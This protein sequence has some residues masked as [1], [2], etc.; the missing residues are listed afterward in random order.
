MPNQ[1]PA[2]LTYASFSDAFFDSSPSKE[3]SYTSSPAEPLVS[4]GQRNSGGDPPT[5]HIL[6]PKGPFPIEPVVVPSIQFAIGT[7]SSEYSA[8]LSIGLWLLVIMLLPK[9]LAELERKF[10]FQV[11]KWSKSKETAKQIKARPTGKDFSFQDLRYRDFSGQNLA[12][13]NFTG[14]NMMGCCLA[15]CNLEDA[16]LDGANLTNANMTEA[17]CTRASL[18]PNAGDFFRPVLLRDAVSTTTQSI[19]L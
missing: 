11:R 10:S 16:R 7:I 4:P 9:I 14:A 6:S 8:S 2:I 19:F 3:A 17:I 18:T 5:E 15:R 12:K 13:S 1:S